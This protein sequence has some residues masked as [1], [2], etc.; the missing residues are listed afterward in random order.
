MI[1]VN[2]IIL[3]LS[4]IGVFLVVSNLY[5]DNVHE[6]Q[7]NTENILAR[8]SD[9]NDINNINDELLFD[10]K[11]EI[12]KSINIASKIGGIFVLFME[13]FKNQIIYLSYIVFFFPLFNVVILFIY[14]R[15]RLAIN[16]K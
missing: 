12:I 11:S 16:E 13:S 6:K 4:F 3:M 1:V 14:Y 7:I 2:V 15:T 8:S 5:F 10:K 9:Y